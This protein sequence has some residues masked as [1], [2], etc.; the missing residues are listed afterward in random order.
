MMGMRL[1]ALVLLLAACAPLRWEG[2][3]PKEPSE[4]GRAAAPVARTPEPALPAVTELQ[5]QTALYDSD[6]GPDTVDTSGYPLQQRYNYRVYA[7]ACSR[8]HS[9]ARSINSPLVGRGWWEFY[10]ASMRAR[11]TWSGRPL[12]SEERDAV[13][14]F[15][16]YDGRERKKAHAKEFE[17]LR[18]ELR[19]RFDALMDERM[20]RLQNSPRVPAP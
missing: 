17:K 10:V 4:P 12:T 14:D 8:C 11:S 18:A 9:L 13:L 3:V 7:S 20:G 19:R 6:L 2:G 5:K 15:L 1:T 16:E